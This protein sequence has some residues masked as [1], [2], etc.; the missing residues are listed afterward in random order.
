M[1]VTLKLRPHPTGTLADQVVR[2]AMTDV[3]PLLL[4]AAFVW[5]V[6]RPRRGV[7]A[8]SADRA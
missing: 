7:A 8:S 3:V 6:L 5:S 1:L 2:G 4:L